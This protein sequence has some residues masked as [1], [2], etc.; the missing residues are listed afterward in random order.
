MARTRRQ[1]RWTDTSR[2]DQLQFIAL[3]V[4]MVIVVTDII[5]GGILPLWMVFLAG[6]Y[7]FTVGCFVASVVAAT[8]AFK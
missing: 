3:M 1:R 7:V 4:A 5:F 2:S 8:L 6:L